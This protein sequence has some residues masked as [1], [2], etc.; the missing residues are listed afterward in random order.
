MRSPI[1]AAQQEMILDKGISIYEDEALHLTNMVERADKRPKAE[2]WSTYRQ[3]IQHWTQ[4][5]RECAHKDLKQEDFEELEKAILHGDAMDAQIIACLKRYPKR[6][7]IGMLP[8]IQTAGALNDD[9]MAVQELAAEKAEWAAKLSS[10]KAKLVLDWR[11]IQ[12]TQ[13][14]SQS[15]QD[16]L[17]WHECDHQRKQGVLGK[18]WSSSSWPNMSLRPVPMVGRTWPAQWPS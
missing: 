17:E 10:F 8:D 2:A 7:H 16:L 6:F 13:V 9:L 15:L 1:T 11:L 3:A 5:I 12:T 14:G 18:A 4:S